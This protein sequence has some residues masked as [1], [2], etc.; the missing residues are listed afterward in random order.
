M[1][2]HDR[3]FIDEADFNRTIAIDTLGV[4][5]TEFDLSEAR[6]LKLYD[7]GEPPQRSS[8][9][10]TRIT[11]S[12]SGR[13]AATRGPRGGK[14]LPRCVNGIEHGRQDRTLDLTRDRRPHGQ[15]GGQLDRVPNRRTRR[16]RGIRSN[17]KGL[18]RSFT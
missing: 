14:P 4:R 12:I 18:R 8:W 9:T 17:L 15:T 10:S 5:T 1:E 13:S 7:W 2:A 11:R 16:S 3:L 6:A